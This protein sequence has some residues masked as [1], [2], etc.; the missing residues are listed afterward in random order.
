MRDK[1][2]QTFSLG[3][4]LQERLRKSP[5]RKIPV[6]LCR[7]SADIGGIQTLVKISLLLCNCANLVSLWFPLKSGVCNIY[8]PEFLWRWNKHEIAGVTVGAVVFIFFT[9]IFPLPRLWT[10][11]IHSILGHFFPPHHGNGDSPCM[12]S[13]FSPVWVFVIPWT[14]AHQAPLS[15]RFSQTR[16]LEW[17]AMTF[18]RGSFWPQDRTHVSYF[19]CIDRQFFTPSSTWMDQ[20]ASFPGMN[21]WVKEGNHSHSTSVP[22][23]LPVIMSPALEWPLCWRSCQDQKQSWELDGEMGTS[24]IQS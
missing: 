19:S 18:S 6:W 16:I 17:V 21:W 15:M 24:V 12:L 1:F 3:L 10:L 9:F 13:H 14:V 5:S 2:S 22:T 23:W 20:L 8:C 4:F 7:K 11:V